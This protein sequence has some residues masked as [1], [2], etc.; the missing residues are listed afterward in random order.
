MPDWPYYKPIEK[1]LSKPLENGR[2]NSLEF[3]TP[4]AGPSTSSQSTDNPLSQSEEGVLGFLPEYT[5]SSDE[6]E[7]KQELESLS[8][9]S[10]HTLG[11]RYDLEFCFN[12][13]VP[14]LT[15]TGSV[16]A[17]Q[18]SP[19][20]HQEEACQE[21][22]VPEEEEAAGD[23]GHAEAAEEVHA[24]HRG[25]VQGGPPVPA[26]TEP[27]PGP[28]SA[29]AGEDDEPPGEDDS[30]SRL[31]VDGVG[32]QRPREALRSRKPSVFFFHFYKKVIFLFTISPQQQKFSRLI[33]LKNDTATVMSS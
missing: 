14:S 26:P 28:V 5:G 21:V 4:A 33:V 8:S 13:C 20:L 16:S 2:V 25:D 12:E 31:H 6:M 32:G 10:D 29:A 17:P 22:P 3:Q 11:S 23:A 18:L 24:G 7:I 27:P 15:F 30:S 1:I 9:D 19:H